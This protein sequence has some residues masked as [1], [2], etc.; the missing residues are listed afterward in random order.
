MKTPV[1]F[2]LRFYKKYLNWLPGQACR[3]QPTCSEYTYQAV[4]KYGTIQGL[5]LGFRRILRCNPWSQGGY[6]PVK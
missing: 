6:D 5:Y 3:F 1:L 4:S 2:F